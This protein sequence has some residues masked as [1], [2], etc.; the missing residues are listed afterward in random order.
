MP[1][2]DG[3]ASDLVPFHYD[4]SIFDIDTDTNTFAGTV[5][6]HLRVEKPTDRLSVN[7]RDLWFDDKNVFVEVE[8]KK[9]D[10]KCIEVIDDKEKESKT[11]VFDTPVDD[12]SSI[13]VTINYDA[14]LQTN[15][16]GFYRSDYDEQGETKCM[17]STQFEAPD[18]RRAFPCLDEP[19][20]KATFSITL[21]IP[22][23]WTGLSNMPV[24]KTQSLDGGLKQVW[25]EK[26]P[27]MSSYLVAWSC[28]EFEYI[29]SFTANNYYDNKPLPIRIYTT[30]GYS[31]TAEFA[32]QLT[33]KVIDFYTQVF[34][35]KYPLPKLDLLAVHTFSHNAMEN[36]GLVTYRVNALLY[37]DKTSGPS[38][39]KQVCYVIAHEMAHQW[40]GNLV[41]MKWWDELWLNEGFATFVGYMAVDYLKPEW[42]ILDLVVSVSQQPALD[43]DGLRSSHS[44]FVPVNNAVE[45]DQLFDFISY[46]KGC[47]IISMLS[48]Y[49]GSDVFLKGVSKYL[50]ALQ[51]SNGTTVDLW[52][53][54]ADVS[55]KP[56][57]QMMDTWIAKIGFPL[58]DVDWKEDDLVLRQS[59]FLSTGDVEPNEDETLWW[60]PLNISTGAGKTDVLSYKI[61]SFESKTVV[62]E[63]FP[64]KTLFFKLNKD[65]RGFFRV[66]YSPEI[67]Q[68]NI[69]P[70]LDKLSPKDKISLFAD[71]TAIA[72]SGTR[73]STNTITLL[74]LL[75]STIDSQQMGDSYAVWDDLNAK[76]SKLK[77]TFS[78]DQQ[79]IDGITQF[80][81]SLYIKL[82][83]KLL[84]ALK[85]AGTV[86]DSDFLHINL[87]SLVFTECGVLQ[88]PEF[89]EYARSLFKYWENGQIEKIHPSLTQFVFSTICSSPEFSQTEFDLI[90]NEIIKPS[91]LDSREI[92]LKSL[93]LITNMAYLPKI[94]DYVA[95]PQVVP[96]MYCHFM[97]RQLTLNVKARDQFW[98]YFKDNYSRIYS[99]LAAN[100]A[101]LERFIRFVFCNYQSKEM[102]DDFQRFFEVHG[103]VGFER[104]YSQVIDSLKTN[105]SWYQRDHQ[106]V[107][108]WLQQNQ[109]IVD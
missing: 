12:F 20:L 82:G 74:E 2:Y 107:R 104:S 79:I 4:L 46:H 40:F 8:D 50:K 61:D 83:L 30:K 105:Y 58:V 25:F 65:S 44:I 94:L 52:T 70:H 98:T 15:M 76:I 108:V 87:M 71:V 72:I 93:P 57:L 63:K 18:A 103:I 54:I 31:K 22:E 27:K 3:L 7:Y 43:L 23:E 41:T 49:L 69:L 60:L 51:F 9:A 73:L 66:N 81:K 32:S 48:N 17:L 37:N 62:L 26:T 97:T 89:V 91:T 64:L 47:S 39:A 78:Q 5:S 68:N 92:A 86:D 11:L 6:I 19:N 100:T 85:K 45:I 33:P 106:Q 101:V 24:S 13:I 56:I 38:F 75:K 102:I 10:V 29:E 67:L 34:D 88:I 59:R 35:V 109:F 21:V 28:G 14:K 90:V 80:T 96:I 42:S 95:D 77:V 53:S 1:Y 99:N 36:W 16:S 84:T 55:G